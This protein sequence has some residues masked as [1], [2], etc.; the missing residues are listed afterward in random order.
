MEIG[1][2]ELFE[3]LKASLAHHHVWLVIKY[4]ELLQKLRVTPLKCSHSSADLGANW[5]NFVKSLLGHLHPT[6]F[7]VFS[8]VIEKILSAASRCL[9]LHFSSVLPLIS[10]TVQAFSHDYVTLIRILAYQK[11][12]NHQVALLSL[13][14]QDE[15]VNLWVQA[16][17]LAA[18]VTWVGESK[19]WKDH[20]RLCR[21]M[22]ET[23]RLV[24][25]FHQ[26][27]V[28]PAISLTD[29]S[30]EQ[31]LDHLRHTLKLDYTYWAR[32]YFKLD[33][34]GSP[35]TKCL[36][37]RLLRLHGARLC[38][39]SPSKHLSAP[40]VFQAQ[41]V[42]ESTTTNWTPPAV[43][44]CLG[45]NLFSLMRRHGVNVLLRHRP[46]WASARDSFA[47]CGREPGLSTCFPAALSFGHLKLLYFWRGR[48]ALQIGPCHWLRLSI[49]LAEVC[50]HQF[51]AGPGPSPHSL[52][53]QTTPLDF[54]AGPIVPGC[55]S[56]T[57][58]ACCS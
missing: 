23:S 20:T 49:F 54:Q 12:L 53:V 26:R 33:D 1:T 45:R 50:L 36:L 10:E 46:E 8:G 48:G 31:C 38:F 42:A 21:P 40:K 35:A 58:W 28:Y 6:D 47:R 56:C 34:Q 37:L 57:E 30:W 14:L 51:W 3:L 22:K 15:C 32:I 55:C 39:L 52:A 9:W 7:L 24:S 41:H 17:V 29:Y 2:V 44:S 18:G 11:H 19:Y 5:I 43:Q 25:P 27:L 4:F 16:M 13:K